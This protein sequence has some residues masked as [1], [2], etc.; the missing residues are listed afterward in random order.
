MNEKGMNEEYAPE[1]L[2]Q[3]PVCIWAAVWLRLILFLGARIS[4]R[5]RCA[6]QHRKESKPWDGTHFREQNGPAEKRWKLLYLCVRPKVFFVSQR[7]QKIKLR[8]FIHILGFLEWKCDFPLKCMSNTEL[9]CSKNKNMCSCVLNVWS[10][11]A[12]HEHIWVFVVAVS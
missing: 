5:C 8:H 9:H 7:T 3:W 4:C 10:C 6:G 11:G 1:C 2:L 12:D